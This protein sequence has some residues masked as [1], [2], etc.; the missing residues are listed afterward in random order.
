MAEYDL[1]DS[2]YP[3]IPVMNMIN[4]KHCF[5]LT[6]LPDF[7]GATSNAAAPSAAGGFLT[8]IAVPDPRVATSVPSGASGDD[9]TSAR[10][11]RTGG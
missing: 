4:L 3:F 10:R 5:M 2:S 8:A 1:I 6:T 9:T 11:A 7:E